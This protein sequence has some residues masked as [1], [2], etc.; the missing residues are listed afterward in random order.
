M[1]ENIACIDDFAINC[2]STKQ[3]VLCTPQSSQLRTFLVPL[4]DIKNS[5][6]PTRECSQLSMAHQLARRRGPRLP[7]VYGTAGDCTSECR[8]GRKSSLAQFLPPKNNTHF[9]FINDYQ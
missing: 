3:T 2:R 8:T 7:P 4:E 5:D 6:I 9:G 1:K